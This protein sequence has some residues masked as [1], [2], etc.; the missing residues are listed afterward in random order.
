VAVGPVISRS[1]IDKASIEIN[2]L[3]KQLVGAT[4]TARETILN[5]I[6]KNQQIID[7]A[8]KK[9]RNKSTA[10]SD[11]KI[12]KQIQE[13]QAL[14]D[15]AIARNEVTSDSADKVDT[16]AADDDG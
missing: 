3:E 6:A 12:S 11:A 16:S 15:S 1:E 4:G 5:K 2:T 13:E 7:N 14:L 9:K 8:R 10:D